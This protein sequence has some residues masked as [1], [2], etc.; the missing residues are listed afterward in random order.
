MLLSSY[1][2]GIKKFFNVIQT[3][4]IKPIVQA[5]LEK[6]PAALGSIALSITSIISKLYFS[7]LLKGLIDQFENQSQDSNV[8]TTNTQNNQ[9]IEINLA[10]LSLVWFMSTMTNNLV[11]YIRHNWIMRSV[12]ILNGNAFNHVNNLPLTEFGQDNKGN[13]LNIILSSRFITERLFKIS[14]EFSEESATIA[15]TMYTLLQDENNDTFIP[16]VAAALVSLNLSIRLLGISKQNDIKKTV[17]GY[18]NKVIQNTTNVLQNRELIM[19]SKSQDAE[20]RIHGEVFSD[21][22]S[23][24]KEMDNYASMLEISQALISCFGFFLINHHLFSNPRFSSSKGTVAQ[25]NIIY[26]QLITTLDRIGKSINQMAYS[27]SD[28]ENIYRILCIKIK[29]RS[30]DSKEVPSGN[31]TAIQFSNVSF[32]FWKNKKD[33]ITDRN[34]QNAKNKNILIDSSFE[35][36]A[37]KVTLFIGSSGSGKTSIARLIAGLY[38]VDKGRISF[39]TQKERKNEYNKARISLEAAEVQL[40]DNRTIYD[41]IFYN[42]DMQNRN[43]FGEIKFM[44]VIE[45]CLLEEKINNINIAK[46]KI[47]S[48]LELSTGEK[49]RISLAR[50]II[51]AMTNHCSILIL[52][53]PT[54]NLDEVI[55]DEVMTNILDIC[56][57]Q[58]IVIISHEQRIEKYAHCVI[59]LKDEEVLHIKQFKT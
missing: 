23:K 39:I 9:G 50:G 37:R 2:E 45:K 20:S 26:L 21:F 38:E 53:E 10:F 18:E 49:K 59:K 12:E 15:Y 40:F 6:L 56:K 34:I 52:D 16:F 32:G 7:I 1:S 57:E 51:R 29:Q 44:E 35:I 17:R 22:I 47:V 58:T 14:F 5:G 24:S 4:V 31:A 8:A 25:L 54:S 36:P 42:I 11:P 55:W 3:T 46:S 28:I 30:L 13:F 43:E 19:L 27:Y 48:D 33:G 41:N